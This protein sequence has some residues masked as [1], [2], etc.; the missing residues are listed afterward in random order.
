MKDR[1][2]QVTAWL[3][4]QHGLRKFTVDEISAQLKISK[5]TIYK[6]YKGKD[7]IIRA[8]FEESIE[9]D[10]QGILDALDKSDDFQK[11]IRC[12]VHSTHKYPLPV[13]LLNEAKLFYPDV[14]EKIEGL[15]R[16]KIE[17]AKRL[18][19]E[20]AAKGIFKSDVHFPILSRIFQEISDVFTDYDF[21]LANKMTTTE[22]IDVAL[23][24]IFNG[25]LL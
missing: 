2:L 25:I 21:L 11:K 6:Y 14:W 10:K 20:G 18:I 19:E 12:V 15:K 7:E 17:T 16:F 23:N 3:I 5:K 22:A 9:S 24:M 1:I 13:S 4:Q 8:Y